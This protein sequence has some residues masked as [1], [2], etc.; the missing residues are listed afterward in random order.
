L[1][2]A[3]AGLPPVGLEMPDCP[4]CGGSRRAAR[5]VADF[6]P[7]R[8]TRCADC[9]FAYLC[10]RPTE[11]SLRTL[12]ESEAYY[13]L[14][15][16]AGYADYAIQEPALRATFAR[17]MGVLARRGL[18]H[19]SLLEV[20]CGFGYLLDEARDW[21]A[22]RDGTEMAEPARAAAER[23]ADDVYRGGIEAVPLDRRYDVILSSQVIEHVCRPREFL[24]AQWE[25][26]VP[27]GTVVVATPHMGSLWQR[28]LGSR[29]PSFKVP[30]HVLYFE[31]RSLR[32]SMRD[33]GFVDIRRLPWLHAFPLALVARKLGVAVPERLGRRNAWIP[34]TTLALTGRRPSA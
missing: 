33:A 21:F 18:A 1:S 26:L 10:P 28:L 29:W 11:Q 17:V 34:F 2:V 30:E 16:Q 14:G 4:L 6:D 15:D 31:P 20:G 24:C 7:F 5:A 13:A 23:C 12:Y 3:L 9:G 25:R 32:R 19:G 8:V 22:R 27:G